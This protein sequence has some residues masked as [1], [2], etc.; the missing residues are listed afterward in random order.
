MAY[1]RHD[2]YARDRASR[3]PEFARLR[4]ETAIELLNG[5]DEDRRIAMRI[6]RDQ[7]GI[8]EDEIRELERKETAA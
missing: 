8:S 6:M 5:N 3:D 1:I 2:D 7:L 4:R